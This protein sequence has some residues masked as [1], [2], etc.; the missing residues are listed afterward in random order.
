MTDHE[1]YHDPHVGDDSEGEEVVFREVVEK[2]TSS[3]MPTA[4]LEIVTKSDLQEV[5]EGWKIKFQKLTEG[6]RAIQIAKEEI[7]THMDN[8]MRDNCAHDDAQERR[9]KQMQEGLARFLERCDPAHPTPVCPFATP[10]APT[11]ST[12]ITPSRVPSRYRPD[13]HFASPVNQSAPT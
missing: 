5:I 12:S 10:C 8:L 11:M 9:I 2:A 1:E 13:F 7:H 4:P 3:T 6:V